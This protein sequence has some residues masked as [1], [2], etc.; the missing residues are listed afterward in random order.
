MEA[1]DQCEELKMADGNVVRIEG[2][3][4]FVLKCDGYKGEF[5]AWVFPNIDK[6]MILGISWLSKENTHIDWTQVVVVMKKGQN[7]ISL[8]L[9]KSPQWNPI[10]LATEIS[11]MQIDKMLKQEEV[12]R[13]FVGI[14]RLV[15]EE[16]KGM[17]AQE[18]SMTTMKPKWEP[19]LPSPI[20]AILEAFDVV[21]P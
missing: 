16:S 14:I 15:K 10:H 18:E 9:A 17:E 8:P 13:A 6:Q 7:W 11:A 3:V 4:Q 1:E 19:A 5:S 2:R 12:E 21:F 20:H